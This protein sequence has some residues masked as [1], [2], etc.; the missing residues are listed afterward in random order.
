[1]INP[2]YI[3]LQH[4][5]QKFKNTFLLDFIVYTAVL[6]TWSHPT[7]A[8]IYQNFT[9]DNTAA[10]FDYLLSKWQGWNSKAGLLTTVLLFLGTV[11]AMDGFQMPSFIIV[12]LWASWILKLCSIEAQMCAG[13]LL[14]SL[15]LSPPL[16]LKFIP[17]L[18]SS[19]FPFSFFLPHPLFIFK[20]SDYVSHQCYRF[21]NTL[22]PFNPIF[23]GVTCLIV[24]VWKVNFGIKNFSWNLY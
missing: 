5:C 8:W 1:M 6:Y 14:T 18:F 17:L 10:E 19:P 4:V 2:F 11:D 15:R 12:V 13:N 23:F 22:L 9:N 21:H 7:V 24:Y 3:S 20:I 16:F